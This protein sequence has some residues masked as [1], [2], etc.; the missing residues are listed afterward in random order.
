MDND[1]AGKVG[2]EKR[3]ENLHHHGAE[4]KMAEW[5]S[6]CHSGWDVTD[7]LHNFGLGRLRNIIASA[8]LYTSAYAKEASEQM[9]TADWLQPQ[10]L[11]S[12]QPSVEPFNHN[13]CRELSDAGSKISQSGG[14]AL[15]TFQ[16]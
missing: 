2:A 4:V 12:I 5:P 13:C 16:L 11:P 8:P 6:D 9:I 7:E 14:N 15:R 1:V 10:P 3:A